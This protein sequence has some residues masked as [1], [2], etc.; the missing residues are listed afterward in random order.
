MGFEKTASKLS[1]KLTLLPDQ[2]GIYRFISSDGK[3]IYIGKAKNL[4][5]RVHSYFLD[6]NQSDYRVFYLLPNI[7]DVEWVVTH[8]E[9]EALILEDKLIKVHKPKFNIQLKDDKTYPY[10]KV[11]TTEMYPRLTLVREIVKDGSVYFGPYVSV[12]QA[13]ATW[14]IIRKQFPLRQSHMVL[15]GSK[16]YRPCL[17][18]QLKRCFAPCAGLIPVEKYNRMVQSVIQLLK[19]NYDELIA[20]LKLEMEKQAHALQFEEAAILRDQI[21]V[22]RRTLQR[23]RIVSTQKVDRDVFSL[24]RSGGFAGVQVLFIRNG[25]LLSDDFFLYKKAE[26]FDDPEIIRSTLSRLYLAG[27]RLVPAEILLPFIY[28]DAAM[29]E[30]FCLLQKESRTKILVPLRGE[31]KA[32]LE[33]AS[34]N[35]EQNL[36]VK[37]SA[38]QADE[39][40][41][42]EVQK[43]L[44]LK[45]LPQRV[46]CF[47]ISNISG[48]NNVAAM[49]VWE[50]NH[51]SKK[52]Y[53]KYRIESVQG[54][55]DYAAMEEVL[56]RRYRKLK[57]Q[58]QPAPDLILI[59]G[60]K[61]QLS[62]AKKVLEAN[63]VDLEKIDLIG[64]A[65]G[66]S[67]KNAG[68]EKGQMDFEY[69]VKP[70]RKNIIPLKK[71]S[72]TLFFLQNIRDEAHRFAIDYFRQLHGK[73]G[74]KS[75]LEEIRGI[76]D[77]KHK[78]L[79]QQF[80]NMTAI[81]KAEVEELESVQGISKNDAH[82]IY[83]F[84]H[85]LPAE[86]L[87]KSGDPET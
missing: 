28:D 70:A 2:P 66:R 69:V 13:R 60:G 76:G 86:D 8:T 55:N 17:N 9:A 59:D 15:D 79:L 34:K 25:I 78:Q 50:N 46:E 24:V 85:P 61:G 26:R 31:K 4:K 84:F 30:A 53:R 29:F 35:G 14:R 80:K 48:T 72:S 73:T 18:Y 47:D 75:G 32:L 81:R 39:N 45:N 38:I 83:R 23:Q 44:K 10:F 57:E 68:I 12:T 77:V 42:Q 3:I 82:T 64:L 36:A 74:L 7:A 62:S 65:K 52:E 11:S 5:L 49:V 43:T 16:T 20:G 51:S 1:E 27:D 67:E 40:I 37:L 19:G 41:M 56:G 58:Q 63:G 22:V 6:S 33:L 21:N 87:K 54:A 71:N